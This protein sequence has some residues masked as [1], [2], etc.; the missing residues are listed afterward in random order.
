MAKIKTSMVCDSVGEEGA[1]FSIVVPPAGKSNT[2]PP[3]KRMQ[4][5]NVPNDPANS[6][7]VGFTYE[8]SLDSKLAKS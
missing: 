3:D 4:L 7:S 2:P 5:L 6:F 8:L 1:N